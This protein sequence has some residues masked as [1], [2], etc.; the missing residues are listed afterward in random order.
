MSIETYEHK[1]FKIQVTQDEDAQCP[2]EESNVATLVCFHKL[3]NLGDKDHG[4][5]FK[6]YGSW[7]EMEAAIRKEE[8][9]AV[10]QPLYLMDHSGLSIRTT[11]FG[12]PWDSGQIGFAWISRKQAMSVFNRKNMSKKLL[13]DL[14][15]IIV[16]EVKTYDDYLTGAV[17]V[18]AIENPDGEVV[19]ACGGHFGYDSVKEDGYAIQEAKESIDLMA[20]DYEAAKR[21]EALPENRKDQLTLGLPG[22]S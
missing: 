22:I 4:Y 3:Y 2:R 9:V 14:N 20:A 12:C 16:N 1:G 5:S 8:D 10:I 13:A 19:E 21:L 17:Y 7:D 18:V 6:D 11:P 15:T